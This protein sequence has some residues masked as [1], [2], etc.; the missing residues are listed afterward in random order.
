MVY[1]IAFWL[2]A[3]GLL[4]HAKVRSV[5]KRKFVD[6]LAMKNHATNHNTDEWHRWSIEAVAR[7]RRLGGID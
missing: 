7:A 4:L 1:M 6:R 5:K 2:V 3:L